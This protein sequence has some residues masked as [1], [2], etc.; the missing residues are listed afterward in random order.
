MGQAEDMFGKS[1]HFSL[2]TVEL[3]LERDL[4]KLS[5]PSDADATNQGKVAN[6]LPPGQKCTYT[7]MT[8]C[9][10]RASVPKMHSGN[11]SQ[12]MHLYVYD[13]VQIQG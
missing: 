2:N 3:P 9:K 4:E 8:G 6:V 1:K 12:K 5:P 7:V 10:S 13:A 11:S